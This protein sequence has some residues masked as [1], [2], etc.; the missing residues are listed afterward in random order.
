MLEE[1]EI[2]HASSNGLDTSDV[3]NCS[4]HDLLDI[5]SDFSISKTSPPSELMAK[6]TVEYFV[7]LF[8]ASLPWPT[9]L[10][11]QKPSFQPSWLLD[12]FFSSLTL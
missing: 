2:P 3:H 5:N 11:G 7:L 12:S 4:H 1:V 9:S 8:Y 10:L 6:D